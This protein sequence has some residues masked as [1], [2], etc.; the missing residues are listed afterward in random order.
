VKINLFWDVIVCGFK[1][2]QGGCSWFLSN[3]G[4]DAPDNKEVIDKIFI[5]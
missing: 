4:N 3:I 5:K 1:A 2:P